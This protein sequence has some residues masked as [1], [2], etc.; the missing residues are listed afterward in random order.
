MGRFVEV[1][2]FRE[3]GLGL[4]VFLSSKHDGSGIEFRSTDDRRWE[5]HV[6][7]GADNLIVERVRLLNLRVL[8]IQLMLEFTLLSHP[9]FELVFQL[10]DSSGKLRT[11]RTR[12]SAVVRYTMR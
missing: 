3:V 5:T 12:R 11:R 6:F 2:E 8:S 9:A 7:E 1:D 4:N 10:L